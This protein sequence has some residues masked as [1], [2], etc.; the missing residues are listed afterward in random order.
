MARCNILTSMV[1]NL[2]ATQSHSIIG[3]AT[4]GGGVYFT[5]EISLD[6]LAFKPTHALKASTFC[7]L[8]APKT[9]NVHYLG[10]TLSLFKLYTITYFLAWPSPQNQRFYGKVVFL[11]LAQRC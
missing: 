2:R 4:G 6:L 1:Q 10:C 11:V 7:L 9:R 8:S 3:V 5:P